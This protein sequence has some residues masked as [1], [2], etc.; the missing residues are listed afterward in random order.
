MPKPSSNTSDRFGQLPTNRRSLLTGLTAATSLALIPTA[1]GAARGDV[2]LSTPVA[3]TRALARLMGDIRSTQEVATWFAGHTFA[4]EGDLKPLALLFRTEGFCLTS[5]AIKPNGAYRIQERRVTFLKHPETEEL[6]DEWTSPV[7]GK[8]VR[9]VHGYEPDNVL[10]LSPT[11]NSSDKLSISSWVFN[12]SKATIV[13][14]TG[15]DGI[16]NE[17][18][19]RIVRT[20]QFMAEQAD[21]ADE[22]QS[23]VGFVGAFQED[24]PWPTWM[25]HETPGYLFNRSF[26]RKLASPDD[27]PP[28]LTQAARQIFPSMK[29][30]GGEQ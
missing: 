21:I 16:E 10:T 4:V 25:P 14:Q 7:N 2:D 26:M 27:L 3:S 20:R 8:R 18:L 22:T 19:D 29:L 13:V 12:A 11:A 23:S 30:A 5:V 17:P 1:R 9:V 15:M 6:L 28:N 24:Q